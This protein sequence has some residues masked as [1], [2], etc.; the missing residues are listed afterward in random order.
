[1]KSNEEILDEIDDFVA[2]DKNDIIEYDFKIMKKL[3]K[4][5]RSNY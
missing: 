4:Y 3:K 1:M 5:E 2:Y